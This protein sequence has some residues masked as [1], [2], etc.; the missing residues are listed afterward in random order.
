MPARRPAHVKASIRA[1]IINSLWDDN[2]N[3]LDTDY[4]EGV[5]YAYLI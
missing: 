4:L 5:D 2:F 1:A 3:A